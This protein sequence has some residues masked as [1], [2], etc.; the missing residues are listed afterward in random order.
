MI[1][2]AI[3]ARM[4][5]IAYVLLKIYAPCSLYRLVTT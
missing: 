4:G 1:C 3:T 2:Q 5:A